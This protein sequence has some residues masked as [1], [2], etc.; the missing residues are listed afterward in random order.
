MRRRNLNDL[1]GERGIKPEEVLVMRHCPSRVPALLKELPRLAVEKPS[2]FNAYQQSQDEREEKMLRRAKY[3]A[4][5][6]GH[7][8]GKAVFIGLYKVCGATPESREKLRRKP[9]IRELEKF[10]MKLEMKDLTGEDR[11]SCL[12]FDLKLIQSFGDWKG[13]LVVDWPGGAGHG[14]HV[15]CRWVQQNVFPS[16]ILEKN[17]L[18]DTPMLQEQSNPIQIQSPLAKTPTLPVVRAVE[19]EAARAGEEEIDR[20]AGFQ[21][22]PRVRKAVE[23]RATAVV[24]EHLQRDGYEVE[25]VSAKRIGYDLRCLKGQ[26]KKFVEVKGTRSAGS[27]IILT[28]GEVDFN[29]KNIASY[30]LCVVSGISVSNAKSPKASGG[31]LEVEESVDL[32]EDKLKPIAFTYHRTR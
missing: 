17:L 19:M 27:D 32:S 18:P 30:V 25:D 10:G 22:N 15:W 13:M 1:L 11:P 31:T 16:K 20:R 8:S 6:I 29:R 14:E 12:W 3:L 21:T 7:R 23:H 28:A 5:F 24:T 9:A 26:T 2:T 4:S